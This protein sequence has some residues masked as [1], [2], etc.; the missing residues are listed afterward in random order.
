MIGGFI[1]DY[2][3]EIIT[4][5]ID[6]YINTL[7]VERNLSEKS[8]KAYY[9]DLISFNSWLQKNDVTYIDIGVINSYINWLQNTKHMKDTSIKRKYV[10]LK[11]F[12]KFLLIKN[13]ITK[14]PFE[15]M[16][17][18]FKT[19]KRLPKVLSSQ[20]IVKLLKSP[21]EEL[22]NSKSNFKKLITTRNLAII[23]LLYCIG[24]RIGELVNIELKDLDLEE[25]TLLIHGKGRKD[26]LLYI[27]STD[28][29]SILKDW[30]ILREDLTPN[31]KN[32]F[33]N[34]YGNKLTIY[35]IEDIYEKYRKL[36]ELD[37]KSTPH[38]LRH[39]FATQLLNNGADIRAVQEIL[40]HSSITTT[41]I[42]TEVSTERKKQVLLKFN[43]RNLL[44]I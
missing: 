16:R 23:E 24:I 18:S 15:N 3:T 41:Q 22:K 5:N 4:R 19:S 6:I 17:I 14:S 13:S 29:I 33:I 43:G 39:T 30:I 31:C 11:S 2:T 7:K 8:I 34:K 27:S 20:D 1:M 25:Q 36:A 35:S 21:T 40:G 28:V 12:S 10:T 38:H 42:Y 26:R 32:L 44:K 37:V 9:S